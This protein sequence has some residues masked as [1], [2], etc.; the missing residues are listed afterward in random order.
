LLI[1]GDNQV[2]PG[3]KSHGAQKKWDTFHSISLAGM[4][5][6]S[7]NHQEEADAVEF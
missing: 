6:V 2:K 5:V 4:F 3:I 1:G 7:R